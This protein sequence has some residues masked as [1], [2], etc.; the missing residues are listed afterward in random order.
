MDRFVNK[1]VVV[2]G[3]AQGVGRAVAIKCVMEGAVVVFAD[4]LESLCDAAMAEVKSLGGTAIVYGCDLE[5]YQGA[6][7]LVT[8]VIENYGKIDIFVNNVGGAIR[9]KPFWEYSEEEIQEEISRSLWPTL[10]CCRAVIPVMRGQGY[11]SI[12]NIGSAA[13]RW[14]WRVPYSAAKGGVHAMT[15]ALGRELA[16]S[17][18]RI[19]C[20]SPGALAVT[21]RVSARNPNPLNEQE[22]EWRQ[23]AFDQSLEDT[24]MN[25]SGTAE[26]VAS[27]V[28]YLASDD[29]SYITGQTLFVAGGAVG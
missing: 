19:N 17:G 16:E 5:T 24:P 13:T 22:S 23:W 20:V 15:A 18:V 1:I 2:T 28:C 27:T 8:Y 3:A 9:A 26:E 10:W 21:D 6:V 11:G 7:G 12:V 29:A 4:R 14:M 25:R